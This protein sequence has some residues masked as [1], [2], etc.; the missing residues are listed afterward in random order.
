MTGRISVFLALCVL[1]A[2]VVAAIAL[3]GSESE[4]A[5]SPVPSFHVDIGSSASPASTGNTYV[6][7][8]D[9]DGFGDDQLML[10]PLDGPGGTSVTRCV[11]RDVS[12]FGNGGQ[13]RIVT[14]II[15]QDAQEMV[16]G[17]V[18]IYFD[19]SL[20]QVFSSTIT[21]FTAAN[22]FVTGWTGQPVGLI[23][24]TLPPYSGDAGASASGA[25]HTDAIG[26]PKIDNT[27][28]NAFL[29][30]TYQGSRTFAV[31]SESGPNTTTNS[32]PDRNAGHAPNGGVFV[33]INWNLQPASD[34][35]DVLIDLG[36]ED[37]TDPTDQLTGSKFIT[38]LDETLP[39]D[40][41]KQEVIILKDFTE[42]IDGV[43]SVNK[44]IPVPCP[45]PPPPTTSPTAAA[46][47]LIPPEAASRVGTSHELE[48]TVKDEFG[49]PLGDIGVIF[50]VTG[51]D[52]PNAGEV[53]DPNKGECIAN[54]NC[55]T[56]GVGNVSWAYTGDGGVGTDTI[57]ACVVDFPE[58]CD[59]AIKVWFEVSTPTPTPG[60]G[61]PTATPGPGTP[62]ATPGPGT[63]TPTAVLGE[64]QA[65]GGVPSTGN[66]G[67]AG[68]SG[69]DW[70]LYAL[71][72]S[73]LLV[74]GSGGG[75]LWMSRRRIAWPW[76]KN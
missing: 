38:L 60:P 26:P 16:G 55:T 15:I 54:D 40:P 1:G 14:D 59:T 6:E 42:L 29:A 30:G 35:Q 19:P 48:A 23:N 66:P 63:P 62:T 31:S 17:D 33:R 52:A 25:T 56:D 53:S 21:P 27:R 7:D 72:A 65:P 58:L 4:A 45:P 70:P 2:A 20:I 37:R 69:S 13:I 64:E 12:D 11:R 49:F 5:L 36:P 75:L 28:G 24:L 74:A 51:Q 50:E 61:T 39:F 47:T 9:G 71:A 18:R 57:Q 41:D 76:R 3:R 46:I 44:D 32:L 43:I 34:G 68:G 73:L 10:V 67:A 22:D 8:P